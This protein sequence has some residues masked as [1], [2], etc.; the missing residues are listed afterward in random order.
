MKT[1]TICFLNRKGG[2]GSTLFASHTVYYAQALGFSTLGISLDQNNDMAQFL[3]PTL[4]W[5]D[6]TEAIPPGP[7]DL[8]VV[9]V[10]ACSNVAH[11]L[12]PDLWVMLMDSPTAFHN[13]MRAIA[14]ELV[15]PVL[16]V[17]NQRLPDPSDPSPL[18]VPEALA[19]RV[20]FADVRIPRRPELDILPGCLW[21]ND[22]ESAGAR[23]GLE[24]V[25]EVLARVGLHPP[26]APTPRSFPNVPGSASRGIH[27]DYR[28]R[29]EAALAG[30]VAA[31]GQG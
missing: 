3:T 24:L 26:G 8:R 5:A 18:R 30:I 17:W 14:E 1:K 25:S 29:E 23:E 16:C 22:V 15:G 7:W 11:A 21:A 4:P 9:D 10:W 2:V 31:L 6:A 20:T 28:A 27:R 12:R 13:A 19:G